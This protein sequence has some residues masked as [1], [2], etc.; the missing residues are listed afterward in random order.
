MIEF[1]VRFLR[2]IIHQKHNARW[3]ISG[4]AVEGLAKCSANG[5]TYTQGERFNS[6]CFSC[7]C[8]KNFNEKSISH[9]QNCKRHDCGF[10]RFSKE[11]AKG[12]IPVY[13]T[14]AICCP[15]DWRCPDSGTTVSRSSKITL[16]HSAFTC[17]FGK[18]IL[19]PGDILSRNENDRCTI[20]GCRIPPLAYCI[21]KC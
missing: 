10:S 4:N 3:I 5:K 15:I 6:G 16:G 18:L 17:E 7:I 13:Q 2:L 20:C 21:K 12:C 19:N 14:N 9:D 1:V 11:I 8:H